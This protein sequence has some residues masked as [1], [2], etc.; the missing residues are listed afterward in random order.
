MPSLDSYKWPPCLRQLKKEGA[1]RGCNE[2]TVVNMGGGGWG[3]YR[4]R[5]VSCQGAFGRFG[6]LSDTPQ[7]EKWRYT[8]GGGAYEGESGLQTT[9]TYM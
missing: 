7:T 8:A 5:G 4:D 6:C 1:C 2:L 9:K 3:S